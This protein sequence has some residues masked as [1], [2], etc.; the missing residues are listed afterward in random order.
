MT[1]VI[2]SCIIWYILSGCTRLNNGFAEHIDHSVSALLPVGHVRRI[3]LLLH[4]R[5]EARRA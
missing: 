3:A 2:P 5:G 4:T 1:K